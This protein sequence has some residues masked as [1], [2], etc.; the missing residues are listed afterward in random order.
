MN[1]IYLFLFQLYVL[2]FL[3]LLNVNSIMIIVILRV[4][5]LQK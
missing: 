3:F 1:L 2:K 4:F 5:A